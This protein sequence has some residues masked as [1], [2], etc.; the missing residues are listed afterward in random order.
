[1]INTGSTCPP[2]RLSNP[3][4][5]YFADATHRPVLSDLTKA[6]PPRDK[7]SA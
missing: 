6:F 3:S 4:T 7:R 1:M 2:S 5:Q